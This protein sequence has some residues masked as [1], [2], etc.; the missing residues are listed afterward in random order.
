M[1]AIT[2]NAVVRYFKEVRDELGK[3]TWPTRKETLKYSL[4]VI[5]IC[6]GIATYFGLLDWG[7]TIGL[8][9]LVEVTG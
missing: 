9:K 7:L 3:V 8:E 4:L 6:A 5:A 2:Q 1:S